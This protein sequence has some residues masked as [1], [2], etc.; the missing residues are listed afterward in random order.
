MGKISLHVDARLRDARQKAPEL[1]KDVT[2]PV[3]TYQFD[4]Q[5]NFEQLLKIK[6]IPETH[7]T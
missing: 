3:V 7:L 1:S 5:L 2:R 4:M 6:N